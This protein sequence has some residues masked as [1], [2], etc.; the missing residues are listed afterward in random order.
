MASVLSTSNVLTHISSPFLPKCRVW[1]Y[2]CT[3]LGEKVSK[4]LEEEDLVS[5]HSFED[6]THFVPLCLSVYVKLSYGPSTKVVFKV[7]DSLRHSI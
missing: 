2:W 3:M 4:V 1:R 7:L 6:K 5:P